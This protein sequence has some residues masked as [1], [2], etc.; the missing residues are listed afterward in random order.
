MEK[1][2]QKAGRVVHIRKL[3]SNI[4]FFLLSDGVTYSLLLEN[5]LRKDFLRLVRKYDYLYIKGKKET[6]SDI[7]VEDFKVISLCISSVNLSNPKYLHESMISNTRKQE[8]IKKSSDIFLLIS[9]ILR[10]RRYI[11]IKSSTLFDSFYSGSARPFITYSNDKHKDLY[12]RFSA[13]PL[14]KELASGG[15][16][17]VYELGNIYRNETESKKKGSEFRALEY[18][19]TN[20]TLES[21]SKVLIEIITSA[22][23]IKLFKEIEFEKLVKGEDLKKEYDFF[24]E[25]IVP[26]IIE[27]TFV[28]GLPSGLSP[29]VAEDERE[30]LYTKRRLLII[31]GMTIA[32]V[33]Q[34]ER[35]PFKQIDFLKD[36][37]K[38]ERE[39][40]VDYSGY[41]HSQLIG[42]PII[43]I[44][45]LSVDRLIS[46]ITEQDDARNIL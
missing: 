27:P 14:L 5:S 11:E 20:E 41:I 25:T 22:L 45:F 18:C 13:E 26:N 44:C 8:I 4:L 32:E 21:F 38:E 37:F 23:D 31:N 7:L 42:S 30:N 35:D 43:N 2:F 33:Y 17:R 34:N 1:K 40:K 19:S 36:Q 15:F 24:K 28:K 10:E 3:K 46:L 29:F 16:E 12:L 39:Y 9:R 6:G